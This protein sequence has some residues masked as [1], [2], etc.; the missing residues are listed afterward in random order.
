MAGKSNFWDPLRTI[1]QRRSAVSFH[2]PF[3]QPVGLGQPR[4]HWRWLSLWKL[5]DNALHQTIYHWRRQ[6]PQGF[7]SRGLGPGRYHPSIKDQQYYQIIG[8]DMRLLMNTELRIPLS[9]MFSTA[10]FVDA[11]NIWNIHA[12][13]GDSTSTDRRLSLEK[14]GQRKLPFPPVR[15]YGSIYNSYYSGS[16]LAYRCG[17]PTCRRAKDGYSANSIL[18]MPNGEGIT[19]SSTLPLV[20]RSKL[21]M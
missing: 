18:P 3:T 8:G 4:R 21:K 13:S 15:D 2:P 1:H 7:N 11:G 16:T 17:F 14:T 5:E 9:N 19:S 12:V 6:H 20:C 10:V